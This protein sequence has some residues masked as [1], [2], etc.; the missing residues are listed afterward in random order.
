VHH[1]LAVMGI[2][3]VAQGVV[4]VVSRKFFTFRAFF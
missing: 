1:I 3:A 4:R 2:R